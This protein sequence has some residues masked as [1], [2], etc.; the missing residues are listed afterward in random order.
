MSSFCSGPGG[1][2]CLHLLWW[3]HAVEWAFQGNL[4]RSRPPWRVW[5]LSICFKLQDRVQGQMGTLNRSA[6]MPSRQAKSK[7]KGQA[8]T[9]PQLFVGRKTAV[10]STQGDF[11]RTR[12]RLQEILEDADHIFIHYVHHFIVWSLTKHLMGYF[13]FCQEKPPW[14]G[15]P[16]RCQHSDQPHTN[17]MQ[18]IHTS[19]L[20]NYLSG[21]EK[22]LFSFSREYITSDNY[23]YQ[24]WLCGCV[25]V[26]SC[27]GV[28]VGSGFCGCHF[29]VPSFARWEYNF[30]FYAHT[31]PQQ[32]TPA[33]F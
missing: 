33:A 5:A 9:E 26:Q 14:F 3:R 16:N 12:S 4:S 15:K 28:V 31:R 21:R 17:Y 20:I 24:L 25:V 10:L 23:Y 27:G 11:K 18:F 30:I 32:H 22:L 13:G 1:C 6:L 8:D 2:Y 29:A 19:C 7:S